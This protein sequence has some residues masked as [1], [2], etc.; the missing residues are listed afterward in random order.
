M[1]WEQW[2]MLLEK[3]GP[4]VGLFLIMIL[5]Q[6][7]WIN[8]LL[9]RNSAIYDA[10]IKRLADIQ[11]RLLTHIIGPQLSSTSSPTVKELKDGI[12][13]LKDKSEE[14]KDTPKRKD[15]VARMAMTVF[16]LSLLTAGFSVMLLTLQHRV[17]KLKA[18]EQAF[19]FH[20]LRD[21]LQLLAMEGHISTSAF[22]YTTLMQMLNIAI[23]NPGLMKLGDMLR[24]AEIAKKAIGHK[25][26]FKEFQQDVERHDAIV[27][28][29]AKECFFAFV[30]ML[31]SNDSLV[32]LAFV[33]AN[34]SVVKPVLKRLRGFF[35]LL[36]PTHTEAVNLARWY[37]IKGSHLVAA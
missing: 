13:I 3:Y 15:W 22:S 10:E 29:L 33:V 36:V 35:G 9:D 28:Q 14:L 5:A 27:Q 18:K 2:V 23:R 21:Q 16:A 4:L 8:R 34:W 12:K 6:A 24:M 7:W 11:D 17:P 20:A 30:D 1:Q 25:P 26:E 32:R 19:R 37:S 31:I